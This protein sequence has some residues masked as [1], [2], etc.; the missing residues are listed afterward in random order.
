MIFRI[1]FL[2]VNWWDIL[3]V[4]VVTFVFYRLYLVMRGTI[5]IQIFMGLL[6]VFAASFLARAL[7]LQAVT[8]ILRAL[9]DIW[10]IAFIILFQP[11]LRRLLVILGRG[12]LLPSFLRYS[13]EETITEIVDACDEMSQKQIGALIVLIRTTGIRMIAET[14]IPLRAEVSKQLLL[15]IFHPKAPLHDGAVII[16]DR[17]IEAARCTLPLTAQL[18]IDGFVM[19]MRHRSAVGMSEQA[20]V[21]VIIVSEETGIIS[22]AKDG[23]LIRNLSLDALRAMLTVEMNVKRIFD[24]SFKRSEDMEEANA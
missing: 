16:K 14:G 24:E 7:N 15:A 17:S 21:L 1:G 13:L 18:Q 10:V 4:I 11:E 6:I 3:D 23:E 9:T 8:W 12:R 20:D 19:G 5:A 22:V 2:V